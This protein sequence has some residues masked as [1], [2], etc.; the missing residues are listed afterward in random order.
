MIDQVIV[1][2]G[3]LDCE[4]GLYT[5]ANSVQIFRPD[6]L[7]KKDPKYPG[8]SPFSTYNGYKYQGGFSDH[9]PV[10]LDT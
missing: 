6:F 3:L 2:K 10:I 7:L 8:F 9:L 4:K 5:D 1:S